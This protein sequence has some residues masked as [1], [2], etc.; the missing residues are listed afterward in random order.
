MAGGSAVVSFSSPIAAI[1][2]TRS[3]YGRGGKPVDVLVTLPGCVAIADIG[4]GLLLV[5]AYGAIEEGYAITTVHRILLDLTPLL[6][7]PSTRGM[8][9]AGGI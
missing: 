7:N 5:S 9:L 8:V 1:T 2:E 6:D 3:P 4:A